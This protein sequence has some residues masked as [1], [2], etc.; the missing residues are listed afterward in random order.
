[1]KTY[2]VYAS[3]MVQVA[4]VQ[5]NNDIEALRKAKLI[6]HA[7]A[8]AEVKTPLNNYMRKLIHGK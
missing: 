4:T 5:A 1:M 6:T 3:N 8:V 2:A 7:P